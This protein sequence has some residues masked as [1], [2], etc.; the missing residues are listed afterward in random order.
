MNAWIFALYL[1][2]NYNVPIP[3]ALTI[4]DL[5]EQHKRI[6][7]HELAAVMIAESGDDGDYPTD[8]VGKSGEV[9]LGQIMKSV[10]VGYNKRAGD[11]DHVSRDDLFDWRT[12]L[13]VLAYEL[14]R[15][16]RVH[17]TKARCRG[18][19]HHW[20][21]HFLCDFDYREK[22]KTKWRQ[23]LTKEVE[24]WKAYQVSTPESVSVLLYAV[25][26]GRVVDPI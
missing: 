9:G 15:I 6:E 5:A 4:Y 11:P 23:R 13:K 7:P 14:N 12:N 17:A 25:S 19:E 1:T 21:A 3:F 26:G 22:C 16:K 8:S 18:K 10:R 2:V 20:H 24:G